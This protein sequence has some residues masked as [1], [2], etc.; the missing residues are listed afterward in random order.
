MLKI[1][2]QRF[3]K[4]NMPHY[5][6]VI[7]ESHR[8]AKGKFL[9]VLGHYDPRKK[10]AAIAKEKVLHW[11]SK[12]AQVSDTAHNFLIKQQVIKGKKVAKHGVPE[13]KAAEAPA[14]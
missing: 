10:T 14:A 4:K 3:G 8:A 12:G 5:R 2:F 13:K 11:I 6:L 1:R 9:E 7:A